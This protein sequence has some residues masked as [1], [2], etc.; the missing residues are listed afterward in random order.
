MTD[1]PVRV[2]DEQVAELE[3]EFGRDGVVE[4]TYLVALENSRGRMNS[5]LGI[6]DQGFASGDAC[7]IPVPADRRDVTEVSA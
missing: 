1:T 4:L 6:T 3:R 2:T 7:R 5:A